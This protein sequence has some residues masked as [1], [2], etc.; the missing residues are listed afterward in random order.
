MPAWKDDR[1]L[2]AAEPEE[3]AQK[4]RKAR[5]VAASLAGIPRVGGAFQ[6]GGS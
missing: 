4:M 6:A 2:V 3:L 1:R 5:P